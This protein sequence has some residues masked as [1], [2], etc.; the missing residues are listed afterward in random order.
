MYVFKLTVIFFSPIKIKCNEKHFKD[1]RIL[2]F[3]RLVYTI[4]LNV[5]VRLQYNKNDFINL[6]I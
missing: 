5:K 3:V 6:A 1:L 2:T 4:K